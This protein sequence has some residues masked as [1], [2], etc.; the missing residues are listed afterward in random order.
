LAITVMLPSASSRV[1]P[2]RQAFAGDQPALGIAGQ[3]I[4]AVGLL[5]GDTGALPRRVLDAVVFPD[6][7]EQEIAALLPPHRAFGVAAA[8]EPGRQLQD[9]LRGGNDLVEF[10][11]ERVD[12]LGRLGPGDAAIAKGEAAR[13]RHRQHAP[14]R[15]AVPGIHDMSSSRGLLEILARVGRTFEIAP[16][17][18]HFA[19]PAIRGADASP[20]S[21]KP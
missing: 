7:A 3:A 12:S 20:Q 18:P 8:A 13:G 5:L 10:R 17:L 15:N 2:P 16:T 4:G 19:A 11:L 14:A 9:R 6:R 21:E 1:T